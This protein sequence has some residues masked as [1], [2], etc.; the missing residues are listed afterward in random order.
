MKETD[1][2]NLKFPCRFTFNL[3]RDI[4]TGGQYV[5]AQQ[6]KNKKVTMK[7]IKYMD[8]CHFSWDQ[9]KEI[10]LLNVK[11]IKSRDD[12][13]RWLYEYQQKWGIEPSVKEANHE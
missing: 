3:I 6:T 8:V 11:D 13:A 1:L 4:K 5:S 9:N 10:A 12:L 2:S 7:N